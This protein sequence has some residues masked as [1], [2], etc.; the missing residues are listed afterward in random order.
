MHF[1]HPEATRGHG[2][3]SD[4]NTSVAQD[5]FHAVTNIFFQFVVDSYDQ[6]KTATNERI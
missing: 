1:G 5:W 6:I 2:D 3:R 4:D